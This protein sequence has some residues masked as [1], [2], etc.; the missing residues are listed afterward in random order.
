[1]SLPVSSRQST[2]LQLP[3]FERVET[4]ILENWCSAYEF[5]LTGRVIKVIKYTGMN[6]SFQLIHACRKDNKVINLK[7]T[8]FSQR[9]LKSVCR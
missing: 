9:F 6:F 4:I 7:G 8:S 2:H 1:M 5:V 3:I